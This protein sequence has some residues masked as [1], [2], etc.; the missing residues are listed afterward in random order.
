MARFNGFIACLIDW[1]GIASENK[2]A[3]PSAKNN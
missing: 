1:K 3:Q 2:I